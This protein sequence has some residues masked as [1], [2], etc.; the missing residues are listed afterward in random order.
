MANNR[1]FFSGYDLVGLFFAAKS[2]QLIK[3]SFVLGSFGIFFS[4]SNSIVPL[5]GL[6]GGLTGITF[7]SLIMG[8]GKLLAT[9]ISLSYL[10]QGLPTFFAGAYLAHDS[11]LI[12]AALPVI[13]MALFIA[14]PV[15]GQAWGYSIYWLLPVFFSLL[16]V[17]TFFIQALGSTLVAHGVGSV[18]WLYTHSTTAAFWH[19]LIPIV[20]LERLSFALG[21]VLFYTLY[22]KVTQ[23]VSSL[24]RLRIA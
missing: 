16:S 14:H 22:Q 7:L 2:A 23:T 18:I 5:A 24:W 3:L 20:A 15:G 13:C 12:R 17:P 21:M 1:R 11:Y 6:M 19:A 4:A 10:L 8:M 9:G